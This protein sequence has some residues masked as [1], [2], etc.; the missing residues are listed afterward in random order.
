MHA[1]DE[2]VKTQKM[3]KKNEQALVNSLDDAALQ[4]LKKKN[5]KISNFRC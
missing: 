4:V 2:E 3:S 1:F 5:P